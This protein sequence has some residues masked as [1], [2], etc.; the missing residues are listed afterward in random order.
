MAEIKMDELAGDI[1][2]V[3]KDALYIG[4]GF[5]VLAFQKAQTQRQELQKLLDER[6]GAG[7]DQLED[8][9]GSV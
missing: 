3:V 9:R 6:F 8:V 7:K 2:K 4:V 1:A 5:G